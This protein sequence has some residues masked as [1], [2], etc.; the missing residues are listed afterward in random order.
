MKKTKLPPKRG[1][2]ETVVKPMKCTSPWRKKMDRK[3]KVVFCIEMAYGFR[4]YLSQIIVED[5]QTD[6]QRLMII[7]C[8]NHERVVIFGG[9]HLWWKNTLK[10]EE[11]GRRKVNDVDLYVLRFYNRLDDEKKEEASDIFWT[12]SAI[13][14][15]TRKDR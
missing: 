4:A 5:F 6:M 9:T 12:I 13:A 10:V 3:I 1:L 11:L 7:N 8:G 2:S 15:E 14:G